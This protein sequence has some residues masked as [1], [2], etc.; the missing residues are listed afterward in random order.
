MPTDYKS[1][2]R[3][4][5]ALAKQVADEA[6]KHAHNQVLNFALSFSLLPDLYDQDIICLLQSL[7]LA[8]E[9]GGNMHLHDRQQLCLELSGHLL[10]L[11]EI[12]ERNHI[13][14][15]K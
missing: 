12:N 1:M 15:P 4:R 8:I 7:R 5:N 13:G 6:S 14:E 11:H 9:R 3:D 10:H 2:S